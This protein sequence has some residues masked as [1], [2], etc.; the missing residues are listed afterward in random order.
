MVARAVLA[1]CH[2][3]GGCALPDAMQRKQLIALVLSRRGSIQHRDASVRGGPSCTTPLHASHGSR[4]GSADPVMNGTST[5]APITLRG[6]PPVV[7]S[8]VMPFAAL[9]SRT[10]LLH[11]GLHTR[12]TQPYARPPRCISERCAARAAERMVARAVLAGCHLT[13]RRVLPDAMQRKQLRAL[14]PSR[15]GSTQHRDASVTG[16]PSSCVMLHL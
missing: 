16:G 3:T 12:S 9:M 11:E 14:V 5:T 6:A 2:L 7:V 8:V 15:T 4:Q 1:G 13:G 10:S